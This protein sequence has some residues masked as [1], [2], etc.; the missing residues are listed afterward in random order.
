[1][2]QHATVGVGDLDAIVAYEVVGCGDDE[3]SGGTTKLDRVERND[4]DNA[5]DGESHG[6]AVSSGE[7][8]RRLL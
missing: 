3:F 5:A 4:D 8:R 6:S 1:M 7:L 2:V